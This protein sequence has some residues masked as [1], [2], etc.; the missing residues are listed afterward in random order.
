[1][2]LSSNYTGHGHK[3]ICEAICEQLSQAS[4][5]WNTR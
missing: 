1:M 4:R 2:I 5:M 3:S